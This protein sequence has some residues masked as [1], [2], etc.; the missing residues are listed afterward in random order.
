MEL[1]GPFLFRFTADGAFQS[2][3]VLK[4]ELLGAIGTIRL[5]LSQVKPTQSTFTVW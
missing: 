4:T 2:S 1:V 3:C 5:L